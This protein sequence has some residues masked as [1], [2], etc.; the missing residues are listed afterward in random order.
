MN[1]TMEDI[2]RECGVTKMTVSRVLAG[3]NGVKPA[4][5]D[6]IMAVANRLNYEV[7][8]LARNFNSNRSGFIGI[9]TPFDGLLGSTY[10]EQLFMGFRRA[11]K[12]TGLDYALFDTNSAPFN[13][14]EKLRRLYR[15]KRVDGLLI[16]ALHTTDRFLGTLEEL[17]TPMVVVGEQPE[18]P[19]VCSVSCNDE[20]GIDLAC[21]HLFSLGHRRIAF[22]EGPRDFATADRRRAA[23]V[24]FCRD[25]QLENPPIYTQPGDFTVRS[26]RDA[27]RALLHAKPRPTAV[28]AAN[29]RMAFG[30][31]DTA[32]E[33]NLSVPNDISV[34]GFDDL[35][36]AAD[37]HPSLTTVH[38]PVIEMGELS[39][40]TLLESINNNGIPS[41][42]TVM[43]V[44]LAV[45]E[46]TAPPPSE[47]A[48]I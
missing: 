18:C 14:G 8:A 15:Q 7:N 37:R 32:R 23:Y 10:F 33:L 17:R 31:I 35:R 46:S 21:R 13:D 28:V 47:S 9:A 1:I 43:E 44:S 22:V 25:H 36:S 2:A 42:Q 29:D 27:G 38:Q 40:R 41:G 6:K 24:K 48:S 16:I 30:V 26:G 34:A 39:A 19:T 12:D 4:T 3:R 45:R 5:R 20:H 11:L